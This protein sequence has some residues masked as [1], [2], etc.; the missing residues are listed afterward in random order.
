MADQ[1]SY[2]LLP[3]LDTR[4]FY[5]YSISIVLQQYAKETIQ[6]YC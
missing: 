5:L 4:R 3:G 2:T 6:V 1:Q